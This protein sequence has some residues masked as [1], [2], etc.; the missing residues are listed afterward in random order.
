MMPTQEVRQNP[1]DAKLA[2]LE[3]A[4]ARFN[5]ANADE[6]V[7]AARICQQR[8]ENEGVSRS[9]F[10]ITAADRRDGDGIRLRDAG[11]A[12]A[13][14]YL[15]TL[16]DYITISFPSTAAMVLAACDPYF[17]RIARLQPLREVLAPAAAALTAQLA[18]AVE[19]GALEADEGS[20]Q[21]T[22]ARLVG[23][24]LLRTLDTRPVWS[25]GLEPGVQQAFEETCDYATATLGA[26]F[27][28]EVGEADLVAFTPRP[29]QEI[30]QDFF[31][32]HGEIL[33]A[34][35]A[36]GAV[37]ADP[38]LPFVPYDEIEGALGYGTT[39]EWRGDA[40]RLPKPDSGTT[41]RPAWHPLTLTMWRLQG[42]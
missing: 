13:E 8:W 18:T 36:A 3:A 23:E 16:P 24:A 7:A 35:T 9:L 15:A 25:L 41:T 42:R 2:G 6:A 38:D 40:S 39:Y 21:E 32:R 37:L 19:A 12:D 10:E 26:R 29:V 14:L 22:A 5:L 20:L 17:G 33:A 1:L 4:S 34:C 27:G 30:A 28:D 31:R 11:D